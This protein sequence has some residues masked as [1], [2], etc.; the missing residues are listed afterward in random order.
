MAD[1]GGRAP[2]TTPPLHHSTTLPFQGFGF[3]ECL[4]RRV[5]IALPLQ[6]IYT[7]SSPPFVY[8]SLAVACCSCIVLITASVVY[9]A[10]RLLPG[11][12]AT[13]MAD[14]RRHICCGGSPV[15]GL[16]GLGHSCAVEIRTSCQEVQN[17]ILH[18]PPQK[19]TT[20]TRDFKRGRRSALPRN[21]GKVPG[22]HF[23]RCIVHIS[24]LLTATGDWG[25]WGS[26]A[27]PIHHVPHS[28]SALLLTI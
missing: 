27:P 12:I 28:R 19:E 20:Y 6:K 10:Y 18:Y 3:K 2:S 16:G 1:Y 25:F 9:N 11:S 7:N 15:R 23:L 8:F 17:T 26:V 14:K 21:R 22:V 4:R 24:G 13:V 5:W